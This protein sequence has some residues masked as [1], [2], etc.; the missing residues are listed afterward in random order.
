MNAMFDKDFCYFCG[1]RGN[2][3]LHHIV[4][5]RY[6]SL[7]YEKSNLLP[8]CFECHYKIHSDPKKYKK[9]LEVIKKILEE[10]HYDRD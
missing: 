6:K 10:I 9:R 2:I 4:F 7:K 1:R 3:H 5:R 8:L